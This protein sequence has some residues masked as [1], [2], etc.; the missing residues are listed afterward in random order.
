M[1]QITNEDIALLRTPWIWDLGNQVLYDLCR[2]HPNH[3]AEDAIIAKI[4]LIGRSYSASIERRRTVDHLGDEFYQQVVAPALRNSDIDSWLE[5][6]ADTTE[7]GVPGTILIHKKLTELFQSITKLEK[8]SLASKYLH[9]HRP[10]LFFIYD[11]RA[12]R[13]ITKVVPRLNSIPDFDVDECDFE[14]KDFVRRC[15]WLRHSIKE[16]HGLLL[17]PR[18]IDKILLSITDND[19]AVMRTQD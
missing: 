11:S 8:R 4:W 19:L 2:D 3:D 7:P 15:V 6:L 10:D 18:E 13:A 9:F 1:R 12:R 14:Y 17:S 5:N 16:E